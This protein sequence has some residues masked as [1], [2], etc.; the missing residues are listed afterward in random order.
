M[1]KFI[2]A[3]DQTILVDNHLCTISKGDIVILEDEDKET[4]EDEETPEDKTPSFDE[5]MNLVNARNDE[6]EDEG[7]DLTG[8]AE[9]DDTGTTEIDGSQSG[10]QRVG[11]YDDDDDDEDYG[12]NE[13]EDNNIQI[14]SGE[15]DLDSIPIKDKT[16]FKIFNKSE[17][18]E[19]D[20]R[21]QQLKKLLRL[22]LNDNDMENFPNIRVDWEKWK[23]SD[24]HKFNN[25]VD[26][27]LYNNQRDTSSK[28]I[29]HV[30]PYAMSMVDLN[31]W[32]EIKAKGS[33]YTIREIIEKLNLS[34]NWSNYTELGDYVSTSKDDPNSKFA[35]YNLLSLLNQ[36]FRYYKRREESEYDIGSLKKD[37][38]IDYLNLLNQYFYYN[39]YTFVQ[40]SNKGKLFGVWKKK[41]SEDYA[42]LS[43]DAPTER[44]KAR[45]EK[46]WFPIYADPKE[47]SARI[48]LIPKAMHRPTFSTWDKFDIIGGFKNAIMQLFN[49]GNFKM[50]QKGIEKN[51]LGQEKHINWEAIIKLAAPIREFNILAKESTYMPDWD[52]NKLLKLYRMFVDALSSGK[53]SDDKE[54]GSPNIREWNKNFNSGKRAVTRISSPASDFES[55]ID[56]GIPQLWTLV[57]TNN[58]DIIKVVSELE[59]NKTELIKDLKKRAQIKEL[60]KKLEED[61]SEKKFSSIEISNMVEELAKLKNSIWQK[62]WQ[63]LNKVPP[64]VYKGIENN[65]VKLEDNLAKL[66][67]DVEEKIKELEGTGDPNDMEKA[68]QLKS[69]IA[70]NT[71]KK[72]DK[73]TVDEAVVVTSPATIIINEQPFTLHVGDKLIIDNVQ[74]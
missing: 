71:I 30:D 42:V 73:E 65:L 21:V 15:H 18:N 19:N 32:P 72:T 36:T 29:K 41:G 63:I 58:P 5:V 40:N 1:K 47:I 13:L 10:L 20:S 24:I 38:A 52:A 60:E 50:H 14:T 26:A 37:R 22:Y 16:L 2:I 23:Q 31:L 62:D 74:N 70:K 45:K 44:I 28:L 49:T 66:N 56:A 7:E 25:L 68:K 33:E 48:S 27:I 8:T 51:S 69:L 67:D 59:F 3:E 11:D 64:V 17:F 55:I 53:P 61:K 57:N 54:W 12:F 6:N 46:G 4:S 35:S 43:I 9:I 34:D 39:A